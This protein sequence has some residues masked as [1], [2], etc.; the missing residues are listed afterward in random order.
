MC[1]YKPS[2]KEQWLDLH[3]QGDLN[4]DIRIVDFF[5]NYTCMLQHC[6]ST[7]YDQ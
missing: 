1:I 6:C 2:N 5:Y 4:P 3:C 7:H